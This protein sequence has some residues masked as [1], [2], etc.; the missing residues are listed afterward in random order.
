MAKLRKCKYSKGK[1]DTGQYAFVTDEQLIQNLFQSGYTFDE[2]D[3]IMK[4]YLHTVKTD[5]GHTYSMSDSEWDKFKAAAD[6]ARTA[7]TNLDS[8]YNIS[9]KMSP[10]SDGNW[11]PK[12]SAEKK[13]LPFTART[14]SNNMTFMNLLPPSQRMQMMDQAWA[15]Q[16]ADG[17]GADAY[18][19]NY[20]TDTSSDY[21]RI[22][23]SSWTDQTYDSLYSG[24]LKKPE[25]YGKNTAQQAFLLSRDEQKKLFQNQGWIL[26]ETGDYGP[27]SNAVSKL[28]T[29][30][31]IFQKSKNDDGVTRQDLVP[32]FTTRTGQHRNGFIFT[33]DNIEGWMGD[34]K[35]ALVHAGSY[36]SVVYINRKTGKKYQKSWDLNDYGQTTPLGEVLDFVGNPVVVTTGFKRLDDDLSY[37]NGRSGVY[38]INGR[39]FVDRI[40]DISGKPFSFQDI[41]D[42]FSQYRQITYRNP[43]E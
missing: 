31:L 10:T 12:F 34:K 38:D 8:D 40:Q 28:K 33:K 26:D 15:S 18:A 16:G 2:I 25:I 4:Q 7:I 41:D 22:D 13:S 5:K 19:G 6:D 30:P 23:N 36:P 17:D 9:F 3:D 1:N 24:K 14:S 35:D 39:P 37:P 11:I 32:L 27:V 29:Q 42:R 21:G 20:G 43:L